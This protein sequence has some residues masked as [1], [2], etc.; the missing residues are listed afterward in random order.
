MIAVTRDERLQCRYVVGA[1]VERIQDEAAQVRINDVNVLPGH[2]DAQVAGLCCPTKSMSCWQGGRPGQVNVH[3]VTVLDGVV[4]L[5]QQAG[6]VLVATRSFP[7]TH[8]EHHLK[9]G[10]P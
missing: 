9:S 1:A 2:D 8:K 6:R 5:F 4:G 7:K 10:A 3:A